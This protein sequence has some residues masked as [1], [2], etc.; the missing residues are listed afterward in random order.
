MS[1]PG[2]SPRRYQACTGAKQ[3][4]SLIVPSTALLVHAHTFFL[5]HS[6]FSLILLIVFL[7]RFSPLICS[8]SPSAARAFSP[9]SG[10]SFPSPLGVGRFFSSVSV[11]IPLRHV[12]KRNRFLACHYLKKEPKA[13]PLV[14]RVLDGLFI[15]TVVVLFFTS[16]LR[17]AFH[18]SSAVYIDTQISTS[19]PW[20]R[21]GLLWPLLLAQP[22]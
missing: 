19:L 22:C 14:A 7:L 18:L 3:H 17:V 4:L 8:D 9:P 6:L 12:D 10:A 5:S 13:C 2:L 16:I 21:C 15:V 11:A 1:S 20:L